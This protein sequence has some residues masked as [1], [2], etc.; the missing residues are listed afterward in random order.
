MV[1]KPG[2]LQF[3]KQIVIKYTELNY[4]IKFKKKTN[5]KVYPK[6][7]TFF[8]YESFLQSGTEH[9]IKTCSFLPWK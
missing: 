7:E 8:E 4:V 6:N 5:N 1:T 3:F 2:I 9:V